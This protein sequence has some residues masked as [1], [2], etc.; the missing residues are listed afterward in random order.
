MEERE[1]KPIPALREDVRI[2]RGPNEPDG[3]PSWTLYDASGNRF[4]RIGWLEFECLARLNQYDNLA[5]IALAVSKETSL[6]ASEE[7]LSAIID[8]LSFSELIKTPNPGVSEQMAQKVKDKEQAFLTRILHQ[9]LFFMVPLCRPEQFLKKTLPIIAPLLT[10]GFFSAMM[11]L[12]LIAIGLTIG[13][14]DEFFNTFMYFFTWQGMALYGAAIIAVKIIH[15]LA[16]AYM[17]TKHGV[18]VSSMGLAFMVLYPVMFTETTGAWKLTQRRKRILI[19][20][21]GVMAEL[22]IAGLALLSWHILPDGSAKSA[23]FFIATVS[24]VG[25][26][27]INLNPFMRFDGYYLL[28]DALGID[29]LQA[30][31]FALAKW[32]L[33]RF[34]FG[35]GDEKPEIFKP[36]LHKGLLIY[37]YGTWIYRFFLFLGI[38]LLVYN[39]FFQP[40]GLILMVIELAWFIGIPILNEIKIWVKGYK[41]PKGGFAIIRTLFFIGLITLL[42]FIP[43][44]SHISIPA[45]MGATQYTDVYTPIPAK[46][47]SINALAGSAVQKGDSLA[48]LES[49]EL[50][51]KIEQASRDL[52]K[53][54]AQRDRQSRNESLIKSQSI[55]LERIEEIKASLSA[56]NQQKEKLN[57]NAP[58]NGRITANAPYL[59]EGR[60]VD[61]RTPLLQLVNTQSAA[62]YGY[63]NEADMN[64]LEYQY[65]ERVLMSGR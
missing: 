38:A 29:N 40:L 61:T 57:L 56:L 54:Q 32:R 33:R 20:A 18:R 64:I 10:K 50:D 42:I 43:W 7:D 28:S 22:C 35:W 45:V 3:S 5:D 31:A 19:G 16:H 63:F 62:L 26:V 47:V 53:L 51:Y 15:E 8:F 25:S 27:F 12:L 34:L 4:F 55:T 46:I 39:L 23:C 21:G 2:Y 6:S 17:A 37:A 59:H 52:A 14:I 65:I 60:W 30:R 36:P 48:I 49:E 58:F 41:K 1:D 13:R 24:L 11:G 9:Y 44:R